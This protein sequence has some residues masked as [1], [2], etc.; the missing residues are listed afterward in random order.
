MQAGATPTW[1]LTGKLNADLDL[2][3][4]Q[5]RILFG[6]INASSKDMRLFLPLPEGDTHQ[7]VWTKNALQ[8]NYNDNRL[9]V[10]WEHALDNNSTAHADIVFANTQLN[11]DSLLRAPM[12]G[13]MQFNLQNLAPLTALVDQM[14]HFSGALHGQYTLSGTPSAPVIQ[15]QVELA[16]G[17]AEIPLLGITLSPLSLNMTGD[18]KG[19]H[20]LATAQ[21]GQG[22][23]RAESSLPFHQLPSGP[24]PF[25]LS[26][27]SFKAAHLPDF[28]LDVSPDLHLILSK[29]HIEARGTVTIP[30]ARINSMDFHHATAPSA[31]MVVLDEE[32]LPT[33]SVRS[34]PLVTDITLLAGDDVRID[35]YGLRGRIQGSLAV[36]GQPGRPQVGNGTLAVQ[37][38]S[39]TVYGRRL[40]IDIGRLLF[41]GGPLANP[42][43][44]LRSERK[45]DKVTTGVIIDGFLQRPE[46]YFYSSPS[47][48]QSVIVA[49]LLEST[50]IG[51]ET[52]KDT[53]FVG[54]AA[55]KIGL[56]GMVPYLQGMKELTMIDEIKLEPGSNYD[57]FSL[58]FGSWL[59]PDL[60]VSYGKDNNKESGSFNTRYTLGKGFS[61]HT[62]TGAAASGGDIKYEFER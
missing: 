28:D 62:E 18:A 23:V 36:S 27:S 60:Y 17:Q 3:G 9:H 32:V 39:F 34:V 52:R 57:S 41:T 38:G 21:S 5:G 1:P 43:I 22:I 44:E 35:A 13:S 42:G 2:K 51:G 14:A 12:S 26:G 58:V 31:D 6:K 49:N 16:K 30:F 24:Y 56:G 29:Q 25:H 46:M 53:G 10:V 19:L 61:F 48:E 33:S 50:A 20:V 8:A 47:M 54:T 7:V 40:K 37:N 15:G 11:A 55:N 59:T 4:G 45:N